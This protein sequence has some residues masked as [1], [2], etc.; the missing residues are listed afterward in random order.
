MVFTSSI[1]NK[2]R[3]LEKKI[4]NLNEKILLL[5]KELKDAETD[6]IYLSSPAQLQ[7]YLALFNIEDYFTYDISRIY[8]STDLFIISEKETKLLK[9][10]N[11]KK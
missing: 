5:K 6:Y 3:N 9:N 1:K 10:K 8:Q 2:T 11:E 4:H 7:K